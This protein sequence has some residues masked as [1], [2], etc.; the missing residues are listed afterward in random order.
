MPKIV[1]IL[2]ITKDSFSD[3]GKYLAPEK[4]IAHGKR[5]MEEGADIVDLGPASSHPDAEAVSVAEE[6]RRLR[7]IL[8]A[9]Q[10]QGGVLSVDSFHP[11]TQRLAMGQGVEWLNDISGFPHTEFY[12][13]LAKANCS[14]ILM[15]AVSLSHKAVVRDIDRGVLWEHLIAFF[16]KRI[17]ALTKAGVS[18]KRLVLDPGMGFFLGKASENSLF[19]LSQ[20]REIKKKFGLPLLV[21]VSRKSFLQ[22]ITN[23]PASQTL[24]ASLAAELYAISQGADYIR[25]HE[26]APLHQYLRFREQL[27]S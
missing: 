12:G 25:T 18:E 20:L 17:S 21:S 6:G 9:L 1:G 5:L 7:A 24:Y 22:K 15:H 2:N 11:E 27:G 14:L 23:R 3:G 26:P 4:A 13:E 19:I 8:P 10:K 16:E